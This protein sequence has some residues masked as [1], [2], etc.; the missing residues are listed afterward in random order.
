[1]KRPS[2]AVSALPSSHADAG[3]LELRSRR[4]CEG[5]LGDRTRRHRHDLATHAAVH[6]APLLCRYA[7]SALAATASSAAARCTAA[8][9]VQPALYIFRLL[10]LH[11]GSSRGR[12]ALPRGC[13]SRGRAVEPCAW[14]NPGAGG[15]RSRRGPCCLRLSVSAAVGRGG[16][17]AGG[18]VLAASRRRLAVCLGDLSRLGAGGLRRVVR[19]AALPSL[20]DGNMAEHGH[21]PRVAGRTWSPRGPLCNRI[22][23]GRRG[24]LGTLRQRVLFVEAEAIAVLLRSTPLVRGLV[25]SGPPPWPGRNR[26]FAAHPNGFPWPPLATWATAAEN[27]RESG[28]SYYLKRRLRDTRV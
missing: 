1:M 10:W 13:G 16:G 7:Q 8:L 24:G 15:E 3:R 2:N 22:H 14:R 21:T 9:L 17:C 27:A 4:R 25:L 12:R 18:C 19:R 28:S 26:K 20:T 5:P 23:T 11:A 6:A